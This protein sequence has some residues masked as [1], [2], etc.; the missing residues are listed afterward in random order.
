MNRILL[1]GVLSFARHYKGEPFHGL[2]ADAPYEINFRNKGWDNSGI[3]FRPETWRAF[4]HLLYPGAFG[5]TFGGSRTSHRMAV[6]I[7]DA[8]FIIHPMIGWIYGSGFP[9][10]TRI[11]T[12]VDK[13]AG[14]E[15]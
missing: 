15:R 10:A 1:G 2:L 5:M 14:A 3:A 12:Q 11:D 9:K 6:A 8:G 4:W 7:E 13:E